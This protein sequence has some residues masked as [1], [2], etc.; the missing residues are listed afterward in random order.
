MNQIE[1]GK[2]NQCREDR[3]N[4]QRPPRKSVQ[5]TE[6]VSEVKRSSDQ[7]RQRRQFLK[8]A[9]GISAAT[10]L[11]RA[12]A[13]TSAA[14]AGFVMPGDV[15]VYADGPNAN[16]VIK[17]TDVKLGVAVPALA[18][19]PASKAPRDPVK[20]GVVL[21]RVKPA[22]LSAD[23]KKN[24][25]QGVVAYSSVC[26]HQACPVREIGSIGLGKG[27]IICTCHG[28]QYDPA[29]N[30]KVVGGPAPR[31]LPALPLKASATGEL[32]AAAGFTGKVGAGK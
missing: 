14:D 2:Q 4:M 8:L 27:K 12:A 3:N 22:S 21:T 25:V 32:S 10:L 6:Q 23:T 13:E 5:K 15:L 31:R 24:A 26:T 18:V 1:Q 16:K 28:S 17:L 29:D 19:D 9:A 7:I 11:P 30:A 20:S